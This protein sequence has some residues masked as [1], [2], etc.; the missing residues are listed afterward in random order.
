MVVADLM[1]VEVIDA[2]VDQLAGVVDHGI[3]IGS[4]AHCIGD[5]LRCDDRRRLLEMLRSRQILAELAGDDGVGPDSVRLFDRRVAVGS[6]AQSELR[7]DGTIT[8]CRTPAV[9]GLARRPRRPQT[10]AVARRQLGRRRAEGGHDDRHGAG[11]AGRR[12][13][14]PRRRSTRP[15]WSITSPVHS[16]AN[17]PDRFLQLLQAN[18]RRRPANAGDVLVEG[19]AGPD[20]PGESPWHQVGD[21]RRGLGEDHGMDPGGRAGHADGDVQL[22]GALG[23]PPEDR[24]H[25]RRMTLFVDPG[26]EVVGDRHEVEAV[27]FGLAGQLDEASGMVF[28]A[29]QG[30]P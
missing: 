23:D 10:V 6:P 29:R 15:S 17:Q 20:A 18:G 21:G 4:A 16:S 11:P 27:L 30:E 25:E 7:V 24:P 26:V 19:L 3:G 2:S 5:H 14:R 12:S 22:G 9:D 8:A 1:E 13:G 28:L